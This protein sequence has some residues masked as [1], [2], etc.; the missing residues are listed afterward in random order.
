M[1]DKARVILTL[2]C[3]RDC[4]YC[5]NKQDRIKNQMIPL[6]SFEILKGYFEVSITG[7]EPLLYPDLVIKFI[8][9]LRDMNPGITIYMYASIYKPWV[10]MIVKLLDGIHY[11]IHKERNYDDIQ[12]F[13]F[14]QN[15]MY[16]HKFYETK[17]IRLSLDPS[18]QERVE[19]IPLV[20]DEI[21]IKKWKG[22]NENIVPIDEDLYVYEV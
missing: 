2:K 8:N 9:E 1:K 6:K 3:T 10:N 12:N 5:A 11:T 22:P 14:F 21:R 19:I 17:S 7:G 16:V 18:I 15:L 20:W 4:E 13:Y